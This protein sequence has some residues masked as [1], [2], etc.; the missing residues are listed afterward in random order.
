MDWSPRSPGKGVHTEGCKRSR[1]AGT[2]GLDHT[3]LLKH[4]PPGG[5]LKWPA[6]AAPLAKKD[7][8]C[9]AECYEPATGHG[10]ARKLE[11]A[12]HLLRRPATKLI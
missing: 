2:G 6:A 9:C 8:V 12:P 1:E 7:A 4:L 10:V 11:R 3:Y 5:E